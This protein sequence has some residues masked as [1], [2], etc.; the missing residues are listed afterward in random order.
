MAGCISID[1]WI[2]NIRNYYFTNKSVDK[3]KHH[4]VSSFE[5]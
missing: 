1:K 5:R 2:L 4:L 3:W